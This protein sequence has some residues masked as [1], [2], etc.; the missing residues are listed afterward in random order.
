M[1]TL[2]E[3]IVTVQEFGVVR[4]VLVHP[5]SSVVTCI[6]Y[7]LDGVLCMHEISKFLVVEGIVLDDDTLF[8]ALFRWH[9]VCQIQSSHL[10]TIRR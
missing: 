8:D 6:L 3:G 7:N 2:I 10:P 9:F 4:K 5:V 1:S